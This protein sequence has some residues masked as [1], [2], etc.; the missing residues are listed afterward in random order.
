MRNR[1]RCGVSPLAAATP[2][3]YIALSA[4]PRWRKPVGAGANRVM[5]ARIMKGF[6][7]SCFVVLASL[8]AWN[9]PLAGQDKIHNKPGE[10]PTYGGDLASTRYSPLD[11]INKDNFSKLEVAWRLK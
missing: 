11:Q 7:G 4:C 10:W 3:T 2:H 9:I 6:F 5:M 1:T 8:A